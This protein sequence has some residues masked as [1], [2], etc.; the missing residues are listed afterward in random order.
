MGCGKGG[1]RRV[2]NYHLLTLGGEVGGSGRRGDVKG[3]H[4][5]FYGKHLLKRRQAASAS[6]GASV[7]CMGIKIKTLV[8]ITRQGKDGPTINMLHAGVNGMQY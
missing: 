6:C 4:R 2:R 8:V 5:G 3:S 1:R 7:F